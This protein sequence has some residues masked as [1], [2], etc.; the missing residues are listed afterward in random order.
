MLWLLGRLLARPNPKQHSVTHYCVSTN[1]N[2]GFQ[3]YIGNSNGGCYNHG[4][5]Y[6]L[7]YNITTTTT[8]TTTVPKYM[9]IIQVKVD[10][11]VDCGI[12][13]SPRAPHSSS[14]HGSERKYLDSLPGKSHRQRCGKDLWLPSQ[15]YQGWFPMRSCCYSS[16]QYHVHM[17]DRGSHS[18]PS[19]DGKGFTSG[20]R[21]TSN[22]RTVVS[23]HS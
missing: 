15:L 20:S 17:Q 16:F 19:E 8:T 6:Y 14:P 1:T 5:Y 18:I 23:L 22:Q 4:L 9:C 11:W 12:A 2:N 13:E 10:L 21:A 7:L 3:E